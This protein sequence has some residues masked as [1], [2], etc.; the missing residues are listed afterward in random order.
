VFGIHFLFLPEAGGEPVVGPPHRD[1]PTPALRQQSDNRGNR[2]AVGRYE[3]RLEA[4]G[5]RLVF[6]DRT[7]EATD[8]VQTIVIAR[9]GTTRLE[10]G[11]KR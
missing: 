2:V 1:I 10:P 6:A 4:K 3:F 5:A 9:D 7:Y 8:K 11:P